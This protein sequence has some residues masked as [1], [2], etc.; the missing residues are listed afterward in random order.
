MLSKEAELTLPTNSMALKHQ[1]VHY[2][3]TAKLELR[4]NSADVFGGDFTA[5]R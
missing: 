2:L 3:Y 5:A 1:E 4:E